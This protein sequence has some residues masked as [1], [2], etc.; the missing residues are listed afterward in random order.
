M[1]QQ[2]LTL[3]ELLLA[4]TLLATLGIALATWSRII[5]RSIQTLQKSALN[6]RTYDAALRLLY[7]DLTTR[8]APWKITEDGQ[9]LTFSCLSS[10]EGKPLTPCTVS[11]TIGPDS[12]TRTIEKAESETA[13]NQEVHVF[14]ISGKE[15][16]FE[17]H[18]TGSL[19][20]ANINQDRPSKAL[21]I[22][23]WNR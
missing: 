1:K 4:T 20:L 17:S 12:L 6:S 23:D 16:Q 2:G 5:G 18:P 8:I 7:S 14:T 9:K 10:Q 3:L 19:W 13:K 15:H 22:Q 11:W 21:V